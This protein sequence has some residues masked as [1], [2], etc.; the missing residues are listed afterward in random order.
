MKTE[1]IKPNQAHKTIWHFAA[2][3]CVIIVTARLPELIAA[4]AEHVFR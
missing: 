1:N 4:L 2:A 3:L